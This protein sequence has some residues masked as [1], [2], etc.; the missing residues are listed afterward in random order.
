MKKPDRHLVRGLV[1]GI[2]S[3]LGV[4]IGASAAIGASARASSIIIAAGIGGGVA[5]GLSNIL[6][7]YMAEKVAMGRHRKKIERAIL[8][9]DKGLK[10]TKVDEILHEK[11][12]SGGIS[13]GLA[14]IGGSIVPVLP[15]I[16][17]PLLALADMTALFISVAVSLS[18]FSGLG[19]YIG[20]ISRENILLSGLKMTAFAGA[21]AAVA[22]LIRI[23]L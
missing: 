7:A 12:V 2:L 23:A 11:I 21:T 6:G 10:G 13:D 15:F 19:V 14:T 1:D 3:T 18:I 4:V 8:R 22:A 9:E 20:R 5:N 16:L 17:G